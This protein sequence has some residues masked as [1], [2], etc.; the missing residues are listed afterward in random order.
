MFGRQGGF[1]V[2]QAALARANADLAKL[3]KI[4]DYSHLAEEEKKEEDGRTMLQ[5]M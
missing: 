4:S 1:D 3:N 2:D 5:V